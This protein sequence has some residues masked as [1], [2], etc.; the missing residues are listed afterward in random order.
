MKKQSGLLT[1]RGTKRVRRGLMFLALFLV[2]AITP[3]IIIGATRGA[4]ASSEDVTF[5]FELVIDGGVGPNS[6]ILGHVI[7]EYINETNIGGGVTLNDVE[8]VL[9]AE[10]S[11]VH[12]LINVG[13][14]YIITWIES[15]TDGVE[16]KYSI[17]SQT[18]ELQANSTDVEAFADG[19]IHTIIIHTS[20]ASA[21]NITAGF[22]GSRGANASIGGTLGLS[23]SWPTAGATSVSAVK[24]VSNGAMG[25]IVFNAGDGSIIKSFN[26]LNGGSITSGAYGSQSITI[27]FSTG[28]MAPF[29][30]TANVAENIP[31]IRRLIFV[32]GVEELSGFKKVDYYTPGEALPT[33]SYMNTTFKTLS[34]LFTGQT[35]SGWY[36]NPQFT[37][38]AVLTI[39]TGVAGTV[40]YY[41]RWV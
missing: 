36:D 16:S 19:G 41:A 2:I 15:L 40:R 18:Y 21:I 12:L 20:S 8:Y 31:N 28:I 38:S 35:F 4:K 32:G 3:A 5:D 27:T 10:G 14:G 26:S 29:T 37:G 11:D 30:I 33:V 25:T 34:G 6:S 39:P 23:Q 24:S 13:N 1:L 9:L 17:N 22:N 7:A